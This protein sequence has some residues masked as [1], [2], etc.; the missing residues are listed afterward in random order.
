[1]NAL[2]DRTS[3][4]R[5]CVESVRLR[6]ASTNELKRP[7][8]ADGSAPTKGA[9]SEFARMAAKIGKDIQGTTFKL[10]KLAQRESTPPRCS[11][12]GASIRRH[13]E[14]ASSL[15]AAGTRLAESRRGGQVIT[16]MHAL[17][18]S[19]SRVADGRGV[20]RGGVE[21]RDERE[22]LASALDRG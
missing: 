5:S 9:R 22:Q 4:F 2:K 12:A 18:P 14:L 3:E 21:G 1:M 10:E 11:R 20:L 8:L 15:H 19:R 13:A 16:D 17:Q 6:S 7:L